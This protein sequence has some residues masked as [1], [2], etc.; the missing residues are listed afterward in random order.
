MVDNNEWG[1]Y[2]NVMDFML[3]FRAIWLPGSPTIKINPGESIQGPKRYLT[4]YRFLK[5]VPMNM[6]KVSSITVDNDGSYRDVG[7]DSNEIIQIK[8]TDVVELIKED[9][10]E[11]TQ[12]QLDQ[13]PFKLD[14]SVNWLKYSVQDTENIATILNIDISHL[15]KVKGNG[16]RWEIIKLIK[17]KLQK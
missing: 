14:E 6:S 16:R 1:T 10:N 2:F 13:L 4:N 12:E 8:D 3:N 15:E 9:K 11:L 7:I 17:T 5:E